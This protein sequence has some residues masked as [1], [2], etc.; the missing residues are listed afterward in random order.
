MVRRLHAIDAAA[1]KVDHRSRP[2]ERMLPIRKCPRIPTNVP[3][4]QLFFLN[5]DFV[6]IQAESLSQRIDSKDTQAERIKEA[7]EI[8]FGRAPA[9]QEVQYGAEFLAA[10]NKSWPE[11]LEVLMSSNEFNYIN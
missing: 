4:Q 9:Q 10:G 5:S 6:R 3:A 11:Y 1:D 7:Y 2:I 8:L